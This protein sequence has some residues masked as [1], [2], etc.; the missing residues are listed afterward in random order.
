MSG[1]TLVNKRVNECDD[2][3]DPATE[4]TQIGMSSRSFATS[5]TVAK[6][7][8]NTKSEME[9]A[10]KKGRR[11]GGRK[12]AKGREKNTIEYINKVDGALAETNGARK[13][14][15]PVHKYLF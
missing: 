13:I 10:K 15:F 7:R 8:I 6:F 11:R 4:E 2:V 1:R 9:F 14:V 5:S 3:A 12:R